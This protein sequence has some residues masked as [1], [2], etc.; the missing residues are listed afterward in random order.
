MPSQ[1]APRGKTGKRASKDWTLGRKHGGDTRWLSFVVEY[2]QYVVDRWRSLAQARKWVTMRRSD[3]VRSLNKLW[4]YRQKTIRAPGRFWTIAPSNL[5][6]DPLY[7]REKWFPDFASINPGSGLFCREEGKH[8]IYFGG[9]PELVYL[10]PK[11]KM[12]VREAHYAALSGK[13]PEGNPQHLIPTP[14]AFNTCVMPW[15]YLVGHLRL[16]NPDLPAAYKKG[17]THRATYDI[18]RKLPC[19]L[20]LRTVK[21]GEEFCFDYEYE[22][23]KE[24]LTYVSPKD[25]PKDKTE[26]VEPEGD[27]DVTS[28]GEA[29]PAT[30]VSDGTFLV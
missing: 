9:P 28:D 13:T 18:E 14:M 27:G 4:D 1:I 23:G 20:P 6:V 29:V 8:T 12:L 10:S 16:S 25:V 2:L 17:P 30:P 21:V 26:E 7:V 5:P 22:K 11:T 19:L 3:F 15:G 24:I